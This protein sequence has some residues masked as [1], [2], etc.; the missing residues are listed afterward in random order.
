V[1][2]QGDGVLD[3]V[4]FDQMVVDRGQLAGRVR[5][6][7]QGREQ[8]SLAQ[9]LEVHPLEHGLA[10]LLTYLT[11]ATEDSRAVIDDQ[12]TETVAWEDRSGRGRRAT[13]PLVIWSR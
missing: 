12:S 4:L 2:L 1:L 5:R 7:L 9:L 11:L 10:E 3:D 8:V 6:V 13:L